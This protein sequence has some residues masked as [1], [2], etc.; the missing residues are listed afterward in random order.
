MKPLEDE[1]RSPP[2]E[3]LAHERRKQLKWSFIPETMAE[4]LAK[5]EPKLEWL[6]QDLW[7]DKS[8]G[9][10]AGHPGV[11]KTWIAMDMLLSVTTGGLCLAKYVPLVTGATLL[12]EEEASLLN[13]ARRVHALAR[14]RGLKDNDLINFH[15]ITR[16]FLKIPKHERELV[17]FIKAKEIKFVVFD[18]LRRF[19]NAKENS[20][21]EMQPILESFARINFETQASVLLIHHLA[22]SNDIGSTKSI[23]ERMRGSGDLWA[24][25]DCILGV[26]GEEESEICKCS[27]QFRDAESPAP[28][29]IKRHVGAQSGAIG[30]EA[31][32]VVD[33]P[34]FQ[35][36]CEQ[37]KSY[38]LTQ[39]GEAFLTDIAKALEGRKA[40]NLKAVKLMLK[41]GIFVANGNGKLRVPD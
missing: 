5:P 37:A 6:I 13:L 26:E 39:F 22:K 8:R 2:A 12:I 31:I 20:S 34:E 19:H 18:S 32:S 28:I 27:F 35:A 36:K 7:V 1:F 41:Q 23:F 17:E 9:F 11:G 30:L 16:Q 4:L 14:S 3:W 21:D 38:L 33:S 29:T 24:W 10:I 15:H 40:D 25:R